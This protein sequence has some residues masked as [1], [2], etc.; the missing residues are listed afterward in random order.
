MERTCEHTQYFNEDVAT[1]LTPLSLSH[2]VSLSLSLSLTHT[3]ILLLSIPET[4]SPIRNHRFEI[5]DSKSPIQETETEYVFFEKSLLLAGI[6]P[7]ILLST[8][9]SAIH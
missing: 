5:T 3:H 9:E 7:G 4:K 8:R 1:S 6:E 2:S